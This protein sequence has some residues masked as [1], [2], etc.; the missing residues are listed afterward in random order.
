[1]V[2]AMVVIQEYIRSRSLSYKL[3]SDESGSQD[4]LSLRNVLPAFYVLHLGT[5]LACFFFI[6]FIFLRFIIRN[7]HTEFRKFKPRTGS[8]QCPSSRVTAP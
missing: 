6:F 2:G 4:N 5:S 8:N 1:M 7:H 3:S